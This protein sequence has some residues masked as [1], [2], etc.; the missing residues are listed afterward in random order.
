[1]RNLI[2]R[3]NHR[4]TGIL[5]VGFCLALTAG[6]NL[7][8]EDPTDSTQVDYFTDSAQLGQYIREALDRNPQ[9]DE[10]LSRYRASLQKVPQVTAL[11]DPVLGYTQFLRSIETR[12]GPQVNSFMVSQKIPWFGK[13][14]LAGQM[15]VKESAA[16]YETYQALQRELI[17]RTKQ[18]YYELVYIDRALAITAEEQSLLDHYEKLAE[19]RYSSGSGLQQAVIK[20]QTEITKLVDRAKMLDQQRGTLVARLNTLRNQPAE[21]SIAV[22]TQSELPPVALDLQTL[23]ELGEDHRQELKASLAR[24]EKSERAIDLAK[25]QYWPDLTLSAGMINVEGREDPAGLLAPPPDNGK[26]AYNFSIGINIPI[27]RKKYRAGVVEATE[28]LSA[29]KDNYVNLRNNMQFDIRD[30]VLRLQTLGE[31]ID[32]YGNVLIPQAEQALR[33]TES[34]YETGQV[35]ALDLLDSERFLLQSRLLRARYHADYL[36]SLA[37]LERAVGTKF[38]R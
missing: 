21:S 20:L 12:V 7:R 5:F 38:P 2:K 18:A 16:L 6:A 28:V 32:L 27:H 25:K 10:A 14:D 34:A 29:N 11:P 36:K 3:L 35:G 23:Y 26:N 15:A 4:R 19:S 8:A 31:Q 30:Q 1:M 9:L 13:L 22:T 37:E 33:S 17:D 24:I